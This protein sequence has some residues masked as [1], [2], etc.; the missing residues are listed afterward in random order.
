MEEE[1]DIQGTPQSKR[2]IWEANLRAK[3]PDRDFSN[4]DDLYDASMSGYDEE[5]GRNKQMSAANAELMERALN[6]PEAFEVLKSVFDEDDETYQTLRS[7]RESRLA[8]EKAKADAQEEF[9]SKMMN[10]EPTVNAW[11]EK[12]GMSEEEF[13][14]FFQNAYLKGMLERPRTEGITDGFLDDLYRYYN[15]ETDIA[16]ADKAGYLR[17]KGEKF[18]ERRIAKQ[19]DGLPN[20]KQGGGGASGTG[21]AVVDDFFSFNRRK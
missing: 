17:G 12:N 16:D 5:R 2:E 3:Y 21:N 11:R 15:R 7:E 14:D 6:N 20:L 1:K 10:S 4:E 9:I 8:E 18:N 19:A 13:D